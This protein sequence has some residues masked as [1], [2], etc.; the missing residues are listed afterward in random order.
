M[1]GYKLVKKFDFSE[2]DNNVLRKKDFIIEIRAKKKD[3][4][5]TL[6]AILII[7]DQT[8]TD[9]TME[10]FDSKYQYYLSKIEKV[11]DKKQAIKLIKKMVVE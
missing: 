8:F 10:L 11:Q 9:I 4:A 7:R 2:F 1:G 5:K 6:L 3:M